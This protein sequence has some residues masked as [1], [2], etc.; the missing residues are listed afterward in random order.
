LQ[1]GFSVLEVTLMQTKTLVWSLRFFLGGDSEFFLVGGPPDRPRVNIG[2]CLLIVQPSS[3]QECQISYQVIYWYPLG[4][5][6]IAIFL[7]FRNTLSIRINLNNPP[8]L[9]DFLIPRPNPAQYFMNIHNFYSNP[10][11]KTH[12]PTNPSETDVIKRKLLSRRNLRR[13]LR[14]VLSSLKSLKWTTAAE[15]MTVD[16]NCCTLMLKTRTDDKAPCNKALVEAAM[17]CTF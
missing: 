11:D 10:S 1:A 16:N 8:N 6:V 2:C 12:Q 4:I 3:E 13:S 15:W 14:H 5:T 9:V 7:Q 17:L